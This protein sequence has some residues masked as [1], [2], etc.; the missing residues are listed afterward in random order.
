MAWCV[1][2][3]SYMNI[4]L[5]YLMMGPSDKTSSS[6]VLCL[7]AC[8]SE[9]RAENLNGFRILFELCSDLPWNKTSHIDCVVQNFKY[10]F[11]YSLNCNQIPKKNPMYS[12]LIVNI[13]LWRPT[14]ASISC[15]SFYRFKLRFIQLEFT[16]Y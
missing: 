4:K 16:F 15:F 6:M 8:V 10:Y 11:E 9:L 13:P 5:I 3:G 12:S 2:G 1:C 14:W 7:R